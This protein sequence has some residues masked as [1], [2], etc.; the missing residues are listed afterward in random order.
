[1]S[2]THTW[3]FWALL[4]AVFAALTAIFAKIG[5]EN[6]NPDFAAFIRT[7]VILA[8]AGGIVVAT[9]TES[10]CQRYVLP[11]ENGDEAIAALSLFDGSR[12]SSSRPSRSAA[13]GVRYR[14][15]RAIPVQPLGAVDVAG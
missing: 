13:H 14:R 4:S 2:A 3:F 5:V 8:A 10:S 11:G 7:I 1:M 15:K 9:G 12:G 6:V